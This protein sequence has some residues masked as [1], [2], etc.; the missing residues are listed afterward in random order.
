[1][2]IG[3]MTSGQPWRIKESVP[4]KSNST[5]LIWLRGLKLGLNSINPRNAFVENIGV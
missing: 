3:S 2:N 5:W 4:S 1:M